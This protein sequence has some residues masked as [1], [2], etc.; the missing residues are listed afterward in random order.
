MT[1]T[2][3]KPDIEFRRWNGMSFFYL[4]EEVKNIGLGSETL[5]KLLIR[6]VLLKDAILKADRRRNPFSPKPKKVE[7]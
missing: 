3:N 4:P 5:G 2:S 7:G 6:A 1:E